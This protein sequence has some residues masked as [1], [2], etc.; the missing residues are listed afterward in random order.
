[1]EPT[2]AQ[3]NCA[4]QFPVVAGAAKVNIKKSCSDKN[5]YDNMVKDDFE[6]VIYF[7]NIMILMNL[8]WLLLLK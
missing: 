5:K 7:Q 8:F 6:F 1:M 3:V 4:F 2:S